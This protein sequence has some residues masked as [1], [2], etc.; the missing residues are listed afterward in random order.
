MA[1]TIVREARSRDPAGTVKKP[2]NS[3]FLE[4]CRSSCYTENSIPCCF[5]STLCRSQVCGCT[6]HTLVTASRPLWR[7]EGRSRVMLVELKCE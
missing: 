2:F 5:V 1:D 3:L 7:A 4:E 6:R